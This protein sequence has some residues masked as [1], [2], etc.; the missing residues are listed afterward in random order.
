MPFP[1]LGANEQWCLKAGLENPKVHHW[2]PARLV[3][4]EK[5]LQS[6]STFHCSLLT[7]CQLLRT[8]VA[9]TYQCGERSAKV[10]CRALP[11]LGTFPLS[12]N[13]AV[14][15]GIKLKT[16]LS[17]HQLNHPS[18]HLQEACHIGL[19]CSW[20]LS[21]PSNEASKKKSQR[22]ITTFSHEAKHRNRNVSHPEPCHPVGHTH[23]IPNL[24]C[25]DKRGTVG[26]KLILL[27]RACTFV[28][29][30]GLVS[31]LFFLFRRYY[32]RFMFSL[33][34]LFLSLVSFLRQDL[35][36][37]VCLW[38]HYLVKASL[39]SALLPCLDLLSDRIIG[40]S[41]HI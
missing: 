34:F 5:S 38:T 21:S 36:N 12:F 18:H 17:T 13:L 27:A 29:W 35:A 2:N 22:K 40:I 4:S 37:L 24:F 11:M 7:I 15:H 8:T 41:H 9:L 23:L 30:L 20:Y 31:F 19:F 32:F 10:E 26:H 3:D 33:L 14:T 1:D 6:F 28:V 39:S 16:W 25:V